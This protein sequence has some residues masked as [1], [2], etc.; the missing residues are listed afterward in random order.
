MSTKTKPAAR[1]NCTTYKLLLFFFAFVFVFFGS[2]E[3]YKLRLSLLLLFRISCLLTLILLLPLIL[4]VQKSHAWRYFAIL[5]T[6]PH[7]LRHLCDGEKT[8]HGFARNAP[9]LQNQMSLECASQP[10]NW[11]QLGDRTVEDNEDDSWVC[12]KH[13][14]DSKT[15]GSSWAPFIRP[16]RDVEAIERCRRNTTRGL[17][18]TLPGRKIIK[19]R[20]IGD[21]QEIERSRSTTNTRGFARDG[22]RMSK[23]R[24]LMH[25]FQPSD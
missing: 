16:I 1:G 5:S 2:F 18:E 20:S 13:C 12:E 9:H 23:P 21:V 7:I 14:P 6:V 8:I 17:R 24:D 3:L 19:S 10:S 22:A 4:F 25:P 15:K 11:R